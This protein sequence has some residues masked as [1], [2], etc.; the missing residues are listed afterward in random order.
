MVWLTCGHQCLVKSQHVE[1]NTYLHYMRDA[2]QCQLCLSQYYCTC[3]YQT[4]GINTHQVYIC[5]SLLGTFPR[6]NSS[7]LQCNYITH[8][9]SSLVKLHILHYIKRKNNITLILFEC[10]NESKQAH[11]SLISAHQHC[12][13]TETVIKILLQQIPS[14][15]TPH[16]TLLRLNKIDNQYKLHR[17]YLIL[18]IKIKCGDKYH[19]NIMH[20]YI[21]QC[22]YELIPLTCDVCQ[23]YRRHVVTVGKSIQ[24]YTDS[25]IHFCSKL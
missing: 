10:I 5:S 24:Q 12:Q 11:C 2:Q 16:S 8:S 17:R 15:K 19:T 18:F 9:T 13:N 4:S 7:N 1:H 14:T 6:E 25:K 22:S 23:H 3:S 20:T 21:L